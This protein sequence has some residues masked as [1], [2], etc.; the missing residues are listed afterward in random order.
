MS[1]LKIFLNFLSRLAGI[2]ILIFSI[3]YGINHEATGVRYGVFHL[4]SL[5]LV[6]LGLVGM[7][8]ASF[9]IEILAEMFWNVLTLSPAI[10]SRKFEKVEENLV[11]LT[12]VYYERGAAA[13]LE[14]VQALQLPGVWQFMAK[15]LEARLPLEDIAQIIQNRATQTNEHLFVQIRILQ[16]ISTI[17]PAVGMT[18]T[19]FGLIKLLKDLADFSSLGSNMALAFITA[20]YGLIIGNF[21]FIPMVNKLNAARE[22]MMQLVSQALF[23][24]D[25]VL[26]RKPAD[27]MD[28][29][30]TRAI[31]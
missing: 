9:R 23:W 10:I 19:I 14:R 3:Y 2:A 12:E 31:A 30:E 28:P 26:N 29:H 27:Y 6:G 25:M 11:G 5:C 24:L 1:G 20:L 8:L 21:I 7:L 4:P 22:E 17:A 15:K 18:G 16:G 13:L